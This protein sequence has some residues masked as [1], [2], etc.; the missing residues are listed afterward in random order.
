MWDKNV[1]KKYID[2]VSKSVLVTKVEIMCNQNTLNITFTNKTLDVFN[3][4]LINIS[5]DI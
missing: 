2:D 5:Y 1:I 3:R 4:S